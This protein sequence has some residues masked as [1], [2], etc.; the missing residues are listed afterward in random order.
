MANVN[1]P[2]GLRAVR[3]YNGGVTRQNVYQIATGLASNVFTGDLVKSTGTTKQITVCAAGDRSIGV[4]DG[5]HYSETDGN[6]VFRRYWPTGTTL[7]T[8][9]TAYAQVYDDPR[10]LFETQGSASIVAADIGAFA[11]ITAATAGS[12]AT[13][14]SGQQL[15][16]TTITAT[17]AT[18]GQLK[19]IELVERADNAFGANAKVHVLINEH[20]LTA[21]T[22]AGEG[23]QAV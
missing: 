16:T 14:Q 7:L 3:H 8:G 19:I 20:E 5:C 15:D 9:S 23:T 11:D 13:G 22:T 10:I 4:F 17:T 12:T 18:G 21:G 1:A 6:V 2:S